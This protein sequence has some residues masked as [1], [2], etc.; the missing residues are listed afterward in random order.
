MNSIRIW[1]V[2]AQTD[3]FPPQYLEAPKPPQVEATQ[4]VPSV[5]ALV[6]HDIHIGHWT[7]M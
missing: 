6:E 2:H 7:S 3:N 5:V 4:V 1:N